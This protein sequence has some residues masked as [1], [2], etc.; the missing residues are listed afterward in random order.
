MFIL[1]KWA[2]FCVPHINGNALNDS[3]LEENHWQA[4]LQ[5]SSKQSGARKS[6][7]CSFFKFLFFLTMSLKIAKVTIPGFRQEMYTRHKGISDCDW[8]NQQRSV[9]SSSEVN[10]QVI[11]LRQ[12]SA[13]SVV[14]THSGHKQP[15]QHSSTLRT[16]PT[17][18]L[19]NQNLLAP[20]HNK[21]TQRTTPNWR[22]PR[23]YPGSR[24][25]QREEL[26]RQQP[27]TPSTWAFTAWVR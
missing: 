1:K 26:P 14:A 8:R 4:L 5:M 18:L 2:S 13:D 15:W 9:F 16:V 3:Q 27:W 22:L 6:F 7:R 23:Q 24:Q 17:P 25:P 11:S 12:Q 10:K 19:H 21:P 20:N